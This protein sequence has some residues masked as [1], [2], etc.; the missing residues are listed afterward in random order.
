MNF[1]VI[2]IVITGVLCFALTVFRGIDIKMIFN[3]DAIL[4]VIGGTITALFIGFPFKRVVEGLK[5]IVNAFVDRR[6]RED[7]SAD[8]LDIAR[9]YRRSD[10][11]TLENRLKNIKDD[12]LR[13]GGNLLINHNDSSDIRNIMERELAIRIVDYNF[14]QNMLRTIARLMPSLG[15]AG[16]VISLIKMFKNVQSVETMAPLM[17][18]ALMST[19]YGVIISNLIILPIS[20]KLNEKVLVTETFMNIMIDGIVAV[21]DMEHPLKIEQKIMGYPDIKVPGQA[22]TGNTLAANKSA[23]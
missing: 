22:V 11:K 8:I 16:T 13:L 6:G 10:I 21:N 15:L 14:S 3:L 9:I 4:I 18:V 5:D 2:T 23:L 7:I 17:A 20:A 19:F 12:F 1:A